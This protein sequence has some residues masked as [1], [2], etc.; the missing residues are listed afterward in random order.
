MPDIEPFSPRG[1]F[2]EGW[3][4]EVDDYAIVCGWA[5]G[6]KLFIVGDVGEDFMV[7]KEIQVSLFGKKMNP[8]LEVF[9][10][11]LSIQMEKFLQ[12]LDKTE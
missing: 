11:C 2:H 9:L 1:M 10:Q 12:H 5:L 8:I 4:A 6:G 7:S 3:S